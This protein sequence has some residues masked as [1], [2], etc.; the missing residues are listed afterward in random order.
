VRYAR[1][2]DGVSI[3][4]QV[5]GDG[6]ID[7]LAIPGFVSHLDIWWNAPTDRLVRRLTAMGR[8]I[9]FDKRGMGLSD[10]PENVA[11]EQWLEDALA[12][13]DAVGSERA[14]V[15]GVSAGSPTALLLA[16]RHPE[17]VRALA[18]HC[19]FARSLVAPDYPIGFD[20]AT[21]DWFAH[22]LEKGWGT[23]SMLEYYAP[24]RAEERY[25]RDYWARYQ[26]LSASPASAMRFLW[27]A[28]HA[29]VRHVLPEIDLPT[30]VVHA[31]G[32]VIV[33]VTFGRYIADNVRGAELVELPSDVH[34]I[35]VS[36]VIEE[37][38]D[39]IEAFIRRI[40]HA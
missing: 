40:V 20:R 36:D 4:F 9:W 27:A 13:L 11:A 7:I 25:V 26:Q 29:D 37:L 10:R 35:C 24:S 34:L 12:V 32:D 28:I 31:D 14:V 18:V 1:C 39:A 3:A 33:P 16:A 6:P 2:A 19:G 23:G 22:N 38:T 30:L 17:R 8:L 5:A 15:L 21:V